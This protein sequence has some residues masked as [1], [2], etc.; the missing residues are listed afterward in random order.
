MSRIRSVKPEFWSSEQ[1]MECSPVVR[2]LFIGLWNFCD[3]AGRHPFAP[4]QIKALVFPG[5]DLTAEDVSR[6]LDEL[7]TNGL[8]L[9]Y[10]VDGKDYLQVTGWQ[11]QKIDRPQPAKYPGIPADHS[12]NARDGGEGIGEEGKG[13]EERG[14]AAAQTG[15]AF[16]GK[17][18]RLKVSDFAKWS[19]SYYAIPDMM[20][21]LTKADDYYSETPPADGKWFFHVSSWMKRAHDDALKAKADP[22]ARIYRG[23]H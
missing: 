6:M 9:R 23:V 3:D 22:D 19:E 14:G 16:V 4:K 11:H 20:A 7:S 1:V 12:S 21:E 15:F 13:K 2:L 8:V 5:D 10:S 17:I 18:V